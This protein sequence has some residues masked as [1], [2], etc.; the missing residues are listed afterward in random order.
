[1][2]TEYVNVYEVDRNYG[3]PEEGGWWFDS[4]EPI[5][6]ITTTNEFSGDIAMMLYDE[7]YKP[8]TYRYSVRP[9]GTD[10]DVRVEDHPATAFPAERPFYE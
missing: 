5:L 9:Q 7:V 3:G 4:G 1:M 6:S 8:T 2:A 10:Y